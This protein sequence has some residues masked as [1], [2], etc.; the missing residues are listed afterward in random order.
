MHN[1]YFIYLF[2]LLGKIPNGIEK[3]GI[4]LIVKNIEDEVLVEVKRKGL[5]F[6]LENILEMR[7]GDYIIFYQAK[8]IES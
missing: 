4:N 6:D 1:S 3:L 8:S 5:A 7:V 2:Y